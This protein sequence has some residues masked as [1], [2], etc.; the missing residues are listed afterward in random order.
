[1]D[2]YIYMLNTVAGYTDEIAVYF[3]RR[4]SSYE[5]RT[6]LEHHQVDK[7]SCFPARNKPA[8]LQTDI[9]AE[10]FNGDVDEF[11]QTRVCC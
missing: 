10:I 9:G 4:K 8:K 7:S 1:M 11:R 5:I 3:L 2:E 6:A